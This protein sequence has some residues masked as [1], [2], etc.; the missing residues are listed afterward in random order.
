M[1][2]AIVAP[3]DRSCGAIAEEL[4]S[5]ATVEVLTT[6]LGPDGSRG[7][8]YDPGETRC[9]AVR[10]RRFRCDYSP[11]A[12]LEERLRAVVRRGGAAIAL[13]E[14]WLQERGPYSSGLLDHVEAN[15]DSFDVFVFFEIEAATTVLGLPAVRSSVL[16]PRVTDWEVIGVPLFLS[17]LVRAGA[18]VFRSDEE[19][20][21]AREK[22]ALIRPTVVEDGSSPE[23]YFE[24]FRL[25]GLS[26]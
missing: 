18:F 14:R 9:G 3:S 1:K 16:V 7:N 23:P 10:M 11:V 19:R 25:M 6:C 12:V 8:Y 5:R 26:T 4:A 2:I 20:E 21:R 17:T 15:R 22:L 24:A 13:Q